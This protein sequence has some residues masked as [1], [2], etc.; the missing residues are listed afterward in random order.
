MKHLLNFAILLLLGTIFYSCKKGPE[1][2]GISFRSRKARITGEWI[3]TNYSSEINSTIANTNAQTSTSKETISSGETD[4]SIKTESGTKT[5][6]ATGTINFHTFEITKDGDYFYSL[7]Y[8]TVANYTDTTISGETLAITKKVTKT[9]NKQGK[10]TFTGK[11]DGSK[12]KENILLSLNSIKENT[13]TETTTTSNGIPT[14]VTN[15]NDTENIFQTGELAEVWQIVQ[16]KNKNIKLEKQVKNSTVGKSST[17]TSIGTSTSDSP[18][19]SS[20]GTVN[21]NFKQ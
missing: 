5:I 17:T 18:L 13:T 11:L 14:T 8:N 20:E 19:V 6:T 7:Q 4:I 16:L 3:G 12:N 9:V 1:D 10:W 15:S 21:L 2:P